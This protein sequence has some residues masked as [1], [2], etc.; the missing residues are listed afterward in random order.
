MG[1][2]PLYDKGPALAY[3]GATEIAEIFE[4]IRWT[5]TSESGEVT[6]MKFGAT[7]VDRVFFGYSA[8]EVVIPAT[9]IALATLATV[10][11]GGTNSG[12]AS[13]AVEVKVAGTGAEV[14]RSMYDN[15]RPL[16]IK[17]IEDGVAAANG[18]WLRLEHTYP[19]PNYDVEFNLT[20]QRVYGISF[21]ALPDATTKQLFSLGKV[22]ETD[23][24]GY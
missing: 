24:T 20:G 19:E 11:P 14:G 23:N 3:W 4:E 1:R 7:P 8:C 5:L 16:Y 2:G 18:R 12:G 21:K 22:A 17:P 10:L 9:R 15:G 13:G 6:E